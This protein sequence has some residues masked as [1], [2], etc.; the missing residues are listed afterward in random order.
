[1]IYD[2]YGCAVLGWDESG[3]GLFPVESIYG[4]IEVKTKIDTTDSLLKAVDQSLEVKKLCQE[5]RSPSH[6]PPF[7]GVFA[8]ESAV[9]GD[10]LFDA[11]KSRP[12]DER[13]DFVFILNPMSTD[14]SDQNSSFYFAHWHYYSRDGGRIEFASADQA[15]QERSDSPDNADKLLT[16]CETEKALLWFYLFF[17]QQLDGMQLTRP[18]LWRYANA[19]TQRLGWR[20]NE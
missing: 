16:F 9:K 14:V 18:N 1:L 20:D 19:S 15:A 7:T 2:P 10:T 6:V 17:T 12:P 13:I 4:V 3:V 8:F 11:L 5:H